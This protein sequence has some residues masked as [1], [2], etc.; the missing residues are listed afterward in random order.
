[1]SDEHSLLAA[2]LTENF[3]EDAAVRKAKLQEVVDR[4]AK[5]QTAENEIIELKSMLKDAA[6]GQDAKE[7]LE[8]AQQQAEQAAESLKASL[9][10]PH[11]FADKACM[12]EIHPGIGGSEAT[13][14]AADLLHMYENYAMKNRWK[15]AVLSL[16][17]T[18]QGG[19]S[20][21]ILH[22]KEPGAYGRLQHEAG[23]HRVQRVPDTETKGRI[24]TSTAAVV[25]LPEVGDPENSSEREFAP[26]EIR[27]DV[28]RASGSGGQHVNKTESAVRIVHIPTGMIVTCQDERSQH[29]NK[30]RALMVLRGRLA[31]LERQKRQKDERA[32]RTAQVSSTERS[33]RIRTY[34][35][36]QN[37]VTD[38]RCGFNGLI[39]TTMAGDL[40]ELLD[41]VG[42]WA[43]SNSVEQLLE[44]AGSAH[45]S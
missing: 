40:D 13:L 8:L 33:D 19:V 31:E 37:R 20:E 23:V 29:K 26:G 4:F 9:V 15:F 42:Q 21:A 18:P 44:E 3:D 16:N 28:M 45:A 39:E 22:I 7:E 17:E 5:L 25:V 12:I 6:L 14:F 30:A 35:F 38:H 34:N 27:I 41:S 36:P 43:V 1:M 32:A 10:P 11:E 2:K 24:H